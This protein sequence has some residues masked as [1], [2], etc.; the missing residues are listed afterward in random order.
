M[1]GHF[2]KAKIIHHLHFTLHVYFHRLNNQQIDLYTIFQTML[3]NDLITDQ[4]G[5][6][7][8]ILCLKPT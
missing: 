6:Y 4:S 1:P 3:S 7:V 2:T 8:I 5:K